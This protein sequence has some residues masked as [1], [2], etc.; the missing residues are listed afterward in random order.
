MH[1]NLCSLTATTVFP[2]QNT[3]FNRD[4]MHISNW[5]DKWRGFM[6][7]F[8]PTDHLCAWF[9]LMCYPFEVGLQGLLVLSWG[10]KVDGSQHL[11]FFRPVKGCQMS[12]SQSPNSSTFVC[13]YSIWQNVCL[14]HQSAL[15]LPEKYIT[16]KKPPQIWKCNWENTV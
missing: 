12:I 10:L 13:I 11:G 3:V 2:Q 14:S 7:V 4:K 6:C 9:R 8:I 5:T 16:A 1:A 15:Y